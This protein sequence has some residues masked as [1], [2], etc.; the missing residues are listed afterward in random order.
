[1]PAWPTC[2]C[3]SSGPAGDETGNRGNKTISSAVHTYGKPICGA[4]SFTSSP[5]YARWLDHPFAMKALGDVALCDGVN[6]FV[7]ND[8]THQ[9]WLDRRPGMTFGAWGIQY[10]RMVTWWPYVRPWHEYLDPLLPP[11]AAGTLRGR[12]VLPA[13]RG[14]AELRRLYPRHLRSAQRRQR[15]PAGHRPAEIRLRRL[16]A[17]TGP[18]RHARRGRAHCAA[19]RHELPAPGAAAG[20]DDDARVAG[21]DQRIGRGRGDRGW[22]A[23]ACGRRAWATIRIA[24]GEWR[25]LAAELWADCDGKNVTEH[26]LGRGKVVW[27][28]TPERVLYE[29]GVGPDFECDSFPGAIRYIHRKSGRNGRLFCRQCGPP[30]AC[31][32]AARSA[33]AASGPSSGIP[34]PAEVEAGRGL[35]DDE[36]QTRR[37]RSTSTLAARCLWCFG[38]TPA[39]KS[40]DR[41]V[42]LTRNGQS[43]FPG[44]ADRQR[45]RKSPSSGPSTACPATPPTAA[46]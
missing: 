5:Q 22:P 28:K 40:A 45:R 11:A 21:E 25:E 46:T 16:L 15:R 4:E 8:F 38:P 17:G 9:P 6:R 41:V 43:I 24:I 12:R 31:R 10:D 1:M 20:P 2:R 34:I 39:V 37:S 30:G 33:S 36:G 29:R 42:S 32:R 26:R 35:L 18:K 13:N 23:A 7:I 19:Q 44:G 3:A 14:R 27:G